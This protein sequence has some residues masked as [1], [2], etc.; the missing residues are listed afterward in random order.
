MKTQPK[1]HISNI[2]E[3]GTFRPQTISPLVVL[4]PRRF[5]PGRFPPS[6]FA[7]LVVS[8]LV[9]SPLVYIWRK[10]AENLL[11]IN[12]SDQQRLSLYTRKPPLLILPV[13]KVTVE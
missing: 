3:S 10:A 12:N 13:F 4:P 5:P 9:D 7:P 6:R 1:Q 2:Y 8:P 11:L